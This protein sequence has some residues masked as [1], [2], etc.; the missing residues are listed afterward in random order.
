MSSRRSGNGSLCGCGA[1]ALFALARTLVCRRDVVG[2][3]DAGAC[4]GT[5]GPLPAIN[6]RALFR[7]LLLA[8]YVRTTRRGGYGCDANG[9]AATPGAPRRDDSRCQDDDRGAGRRLE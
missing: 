9:P 3:L 2:R 1:A 6:P 4:R 5:L 8:P 7:G